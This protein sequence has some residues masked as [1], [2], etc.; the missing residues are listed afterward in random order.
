M[1]FNLQSIVSLVIVIFFLPLSAGSVSKPGPE[2]A[3]KLLKAGNIRFSTGNS[4]HPNTSANR[5]YQAGTESQ[6]DHAFATV[7]TCSDSRVPVERIF[8]AGIMDIF[9]VRVAGN[10]ID[11]DEAGSIEYGLAHVN[12]PVLVVLGH[13]QCGAVTAVTHAVHG[14]GHALERNIPPLVANITPAVE[15]AIEQ[16]PDIHGDEIIPMAIVEN[17]WQGIEDLFMSSPSS[18]DL[19]K[20]NKVKVVGAVYDV[21][22]GLVNWLPEEQV[23]EILKKVEADPGRAIE[24]MAPA[25]GE[26]TSGHAGVGGHSGPSR[27][28]DASHAKVQGH[29]EIKPVEIVLADA[30]TMKILEADLFKGHEPQEHPVESHGLSNTFWCIVAI[31]VG[32]LVLVV[33]VF[34]TKTLDRLNLRVK[35]YTSFGSILVLATVLGGGA[36]V[37]FN[38]VK[39]FAHLEAAFMGV[40]VKAG[41]VRSSQNSFLLN[42]LKDREFGELEVR[43]AESNLRDIV[44]DLEQVRKNG[45]LSE[46]QLAGVEFL[47]GNV[48]EYGK[49]FKEVVTSFREIEELEV[50]LSNASL[51]FE[52]KIEI[53]A[54]H[55]EEM[56]AEAEHKGV[57]LSEIVRQ[58]AIVEHLLTLEI[59]GVKL[60]RAEVEF[61]LDKNPH[62]IATMER[63]LGAFKGYLAA[64]EHEITGQEELQQLKSIETAIGEYELVLRKVV[65][66]VAVIEQD[67]AKMNSLMG[68]FFSSAAELSHVAEMMADSTVK[69]AIFTIIMLITVML[70][71][72]SMLALFLTRLITTPILQSVSFAE[73]IA[74]GDLTQS[75]EVK[76]KDETGLLV[77]A[78]SQ[79]NRSLR[80]MMQDIKSGSLELS[81]SSQALHS[82]ANT[83][84]SGSEDTSQSANTVSAAA[85]EMSVN[86]SSVAAAAEQAATNVNI[87]A[88]A[89]EEMTSTI[90]EITQNTAKTSTMTTKAVEQASSAS[91]K[92]NELGSS[93]QD[94]SKVTETITEISEQ[95]NLLALN[96]TI[97]AARAGEAG[98][99]FAVVANEIK[100][101]AKQTAEATLE[102][103]SKIEGVQNSTQGTVSEITDIT[104]VI[105][106][107]NTMTNAIAAAIE[108]QAAA[109]QE[110]AANVAQAS[111]GIQE[112]TENVSESSVVARDISGEIAGID[113]AATK[114]NTSSADVLSSS[115]QLNEFAESL[116]EMV[117]KFKV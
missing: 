6:G 36:Y 95:T 93:A 55:H 37:N 91:E 102:I 45:H 72:G 81:N 33:V 79:M 9:V 22:T 111:Q 8:D 48:S 14:K 113:S 44:K 20:E 63:E 78:L 98:K 103:K 117:S 28:G 110:I 53:M 61:L 51:G 41:S 56:L 49:K 58:T 15:R 62:H 2:E 99:G 39:R 25:H 100:E 114:L 105:D 10:V 16:H 65:K 77:E 84:A 11:T 71:A 94:I 104:K 1:Q 43:S 18:R 67:S 97:E 101:L 4:S 5:L 7:I 108:E 64:V 30:D 92:V 89:A 27:G 76:Q 23:G 74:N 50:E 86:M 66:D 46:E 38:D 40:E 54:G 115:N 87:V 106:D 26:K 88:A 112:V 35:M 73:A 70:I 24:R 17:V 68:E 57:D 69:E 21:A 82:T 90:A 12:T 59:H 107:V 85:E 109:T 116:K 83:M 47:E 96:A 3:V 13:T 75:L 32:F 42:G 19:Y 34:L 52:S 29:L 80:Q 31:L 60:S